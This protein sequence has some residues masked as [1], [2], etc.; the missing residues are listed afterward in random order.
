MK[1]KLLTT[2]IVCALLIS[3]TGCAADNTEHMFDWLGDIFSGIG[4]AIGDT[5]EYLGTQIA[6]TIFDAILQWFYEIIYGAVADF[7]TMMGNMGAEIFDLSWVQATI[8]LF[9][10]F[11][12]SLFVAG[13]VVAIFDVAIEYQNGRAKPADD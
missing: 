5:I 3:I 13:T 4:N 2:A 7:F 12:W 8:R 10:L 11:G 6:N 9:T 1:T